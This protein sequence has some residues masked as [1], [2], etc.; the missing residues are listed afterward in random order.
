MH[1]YLNRLTATPQPFQ[2][3][4][5]WSSP[6]S[7]CYYCGIRGHISRFCRRREDERR[8]YAGCERNEFSGPVTQCRR[9]Y[10]NYP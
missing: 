2:S 4:N 5:V 9:S 3:Y 8:R 7:F 10:Y 1:G 6:R